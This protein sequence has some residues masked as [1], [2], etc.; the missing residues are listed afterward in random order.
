MTS[1]P[2]K[3]ATPPGAPHLLTN[4][5][6]ISPGIGSTVQRNAW[7]MVRRISQS[8]C[9]STLRRPGIYSYGMISF[10]LTHFLNSYGGG[11]CHDKDE[12]GR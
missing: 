8:T 7:P 11:T 10:K 5:E 12:C 4:M 3:M 2:L 9:V 6:A 1:A